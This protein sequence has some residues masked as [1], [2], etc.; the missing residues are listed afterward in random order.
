VSAHAVIRPEESSG[1]R[2]QLAIARV[3][4]RLTPGNACG[5]IRVLAL[6]VRRQLLLGTGRSSNQYCARVHEGLRHA[7][8]KLLVP[9]GHDDC[10]EHSPCDEYVGADECCDHRGIDFRGVELKDSRLLMIDPDQGVI[11]LNHLE[12]LWSKSH[13]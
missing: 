9:P 11:M 7:F 1:Q 12:S 6:N 5:N 2:H 13:A 3:I 4:E 10:Q 8:Q